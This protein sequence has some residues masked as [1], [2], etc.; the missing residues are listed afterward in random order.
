MAAGPVTRG[1][2]HGRKTTAKRAAVAGVLLLCFGPAI[3]GCSG[4]VLDTVEA[5]SVDTAG[6]ITLPPTSGTFDYQ[7]GGAYDELPGDGANGVEEQG[8]LNVVVR[9]SEAHPPPGNYSVCSVNGSQTQA[10]QADLW[11]DDEDVLLHDDDGD[12]VVDPDWPDEY[13]FDPTTE[14]ARGHPRPPRRGHR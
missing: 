4:S 10:D 12:L 2:T 11:A 3:V 9:D 6:R 7:L 8:N 14:R 5:E 1:S 13:I